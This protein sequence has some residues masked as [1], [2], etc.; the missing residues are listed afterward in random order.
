MTRLCKHILRKLIPHVGSKQSVRLLLSFP[1]PMAWPLLAPPGPKGL[2]S[3]ECC[4]G[5]CFPGGSSFCPYSVLGNHTLTANTH[6][7]HIHTHHTHHTHRLQVPHITPAHRTIYPYPPHTHTH[8]TQH[9]PHN[10]HSPTHAYIKHTHTNHVYTH[11][12]SLTIIQHG[13][14]MCIQLNQKSSVGEFLPRDVRL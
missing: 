3:L 4:L 14:R 9:T 12:H 13:W 5:L 2:F 7:H 1:A 11:T 10:T 8:N 6:T